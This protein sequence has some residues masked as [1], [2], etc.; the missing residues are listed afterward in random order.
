MEIK[1]HIDKPNVVKRYF[2]EEWP[3]A[4][5]LSFE[6]QDEQHNLSN[7]YVSY[8]LDENGWFHFVPEILPVNFHKKWV[9]IFEESMGKKLLHPNGECHFGL[10]M[11]RIDD[12][13]PFLKD[14]QVADHEVIASLVPLLQY[15]KEN[16]KG[17]Y[18]TG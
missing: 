4:E 13:E 2:H 7:G 12:L 14:C 1:V 8:Q 15:A 6:E 3:Y 11:D 5:G 16:C 10:S 9:A 18:I 17:I